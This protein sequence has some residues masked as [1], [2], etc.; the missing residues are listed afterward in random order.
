MKKLPAGTGRYAFGD[1]VLHRLD[2]RVKI[3]CLLIML[4]I[5]IGASSA[6]SYGL[7][8]SAIGMIIL[9]SKLPLREVFG[10]IG[11]L[12]L[13]FGTILLMNALFFNTE[14]TLCSWWI[15]NPSIDGIRQGFSVIVNVVLVLI[16]GN[17][18]TLSTSPTEITTALESLIKPLKLLGVPTEDV[19]MIIS[20]AIQF[21]PTL[22]EETEAIK[23]AQIARGARFESK[24]VRER[25]LSFVPLVV[26]IFL[27]AFKRAD[28]LSLAMEARGYRNAK[29]RTKRKKEPLKLQDYVAACA[30]GTLCLIQFLILR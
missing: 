11:R 16:L 23:M 10:N 6:S 8:L 15:F 28:E 30:C 24:K 20:V 9:L 7:A 12:W 19:A 3:I 27:S 4:A 14:N 18:L 1:S 21:I 5:V 22:M 29:N 26:P 2:A 13:F 17:V 25:A